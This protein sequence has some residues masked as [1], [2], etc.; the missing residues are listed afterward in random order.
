MGRLKRKWRK[1]R[2]QQQDNISLGKLV[3]EAEWEGR[4]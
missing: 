3:A 2:L 1:K 4:A